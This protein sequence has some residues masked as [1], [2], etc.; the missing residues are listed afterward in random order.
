MPADLTPAPAAFPAVRAFFSGCAAGG[1]TSAAFGVA[2]DFGVPIEAE[3][4]VASILS[5]PL[6]PPSRFAIIAVFVA[7]CGVLALGYAWAFR[8]ILGT[9]G[10]GP[11]A[12]LALVHVVASGVAAG[13]LGLWHPHVPPLPRPGFFYS[14]AGPAGML[15]FVAGHIAYGALVGWMLEPRRVAPQSDVDIH[16]RP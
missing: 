2:R 8:K 9:A 6:P 5:P 10:A 7:F 1:V 13:T 15:L 3:R 11:G 12:A 14:G 4:L 16:G